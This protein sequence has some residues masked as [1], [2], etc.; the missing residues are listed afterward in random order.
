MI[1][2]LLKVVKNSIFLT[3][4]TLNND[5]ANIMCKQLS[6]LEQFSINQVFPRVFPKP[7]QFQ[8]SSELMA[9][10]ELHGVKGL[11]MRAIT[12]PDQYWSSCER[13]NNFSPCFAPCEDIAYFIQKQLEIDNYIPCIQAV[14]LLQKQMGVEQWSFSLDDLPTDIVPLIY[15]ELEYLETHLQLPH[16]FQDE[17]LRELYYGYNILLQNGIFTRIGL[18]CIKEFINE[19]L[20]QT[21]SRLY[22]LRLRPRFPGSHHYH[23]D[24][25]SET[26]SDY[27][28]SGEYSD[29]SDF[30]SDDE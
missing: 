29:Y 10:K 23:G 19:L 16:L 21:S 20:S 26:D 4:D 7:T 25:D 27:D 30:D 13:F 17:T 2:I 22:Y 6:A 28:S 3:M 5:V 8:I 24:V 11:M 15:Q 12:T 18:D 14:V 1:N 9:S